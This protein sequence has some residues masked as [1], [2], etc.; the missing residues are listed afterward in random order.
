MVGVKLH[1]NKAP[2]REQTGLLHASGNLRRMLLAGVTG[3][4]HLFIQNRIT[5]SLQGNRQR[6]E[7]LPD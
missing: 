4:S 3:G 5:S 2:L 1:K 7:N 6:A